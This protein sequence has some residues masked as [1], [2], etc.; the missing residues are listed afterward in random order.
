[1]PYV[2]LTNEKKAQL[3]GWLNREKDFLLSIKA[4][5]ERIMVPDATGTLELI[6]RDLEFV[7]RVRTAIR[8]AEDPVDLTDD[9]IEALVTVARKNTYDNRAVFWRSIIE[10]LSQTSTEPTGG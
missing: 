10:S 6:R 2:T 8:G 3:V 7:I 1:M 5:A 4:M 9:D